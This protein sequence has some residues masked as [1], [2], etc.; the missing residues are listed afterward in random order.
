MEAA[1]KMQSRCQCGLFPSKEPSAGHDGFPV[2]VAPPASQ[3]PRGGFGALCCED[4]GG[5]Q[6]YRKTTGWGREV[7]RSWCPSPELVDG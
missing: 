4:S 3:P 1:G 5:C 7:E 6:S 2:E